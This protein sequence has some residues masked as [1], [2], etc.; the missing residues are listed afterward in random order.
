[1]TATEHPIAAM[2]G[3]AWPTATAGCGKQR[4]LTRINKAKTGGKGPNHLILINPEAE[5][6]QDKNSGFSEG[7]TDCQK[8]PDCEET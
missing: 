1:M 2:E 8:T 7:E 3:P 4:Q 5:G 6:G